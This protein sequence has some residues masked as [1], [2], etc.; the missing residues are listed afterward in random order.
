MYGAPLIAK[1]MALRMARHP[2]PQQ[3]PGAIHIAPLEVYWPH[4]QV[5]G[6]PRQIGFRDVDKALLAATI[7][8]AGLALKP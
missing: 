2:Q 4:P 6:H 5:P 7:G 3:V 1:K 8:A